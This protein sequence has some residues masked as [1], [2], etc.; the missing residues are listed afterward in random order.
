MGRKCETGPQGSGPCTV[1]VIMDHERLSR[2]SG[3][4]SPYGKSNLSQFVMT[5]TAPF[6]MR[7][8]RYQ[9]TLLHLH[10]TRVQGMGLMDKCIAYR[11][12]WTPLFKAMPSP[13]VFGPTMPHVYNAAR[14]SMARLKKSGLS[15]AS[16]RLRRTK[17][18]S[19][20]NHLETN[21]SRPEHS[22]ETQATRESRR[23]VN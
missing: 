20:G 5:V 10:D 11:V 22:T 6:M 21:L 14:H 16:F 2:C 19:C 3:T 1:Y 18:G 4:H 17:Y 9:H 13:I 7:P 15:V 23:D 8:K 12:R